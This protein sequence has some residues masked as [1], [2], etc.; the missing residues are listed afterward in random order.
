MN[1]YR[2]CPVGTRLVGQRGQTHKEHWRPVE[3]GGSPG[4]SNNRQ[5]N[6]AVTRGRMEGVIFVQWNQRKLRDGGHDAFELNLEE[7]A[8]IIPV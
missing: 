5:G 4:S 2:P 6:L 1:R 3:S 8:G 7:T